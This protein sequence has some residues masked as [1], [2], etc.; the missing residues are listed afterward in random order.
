MA[1]Y[2]YQAAYTPESL[3]AQMKDPQ[4]RLSV[5]SGQ[6]ASVGASIV[7]GGFCFGEFDLAALIEA[8]DDRTMAA[9]AVS[10]A[11]AG[12]V[13]NAKT[14]PLIPGAEYIEVLKKAGTVG[15]RAAR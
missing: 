11:A 15:Y 4:D 10:I 3:T 1:L 8:P 13:R 5:V 7:G 9:I 2:L 6:L 14:T 12:A